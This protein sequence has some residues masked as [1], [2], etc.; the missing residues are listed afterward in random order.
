MKFSKQL[1]DMATQIGTMELHG[2]TSMQSVECEHE[3]YDL[4][5][6]LMFSKLNNVEVPYKHRFN[7]EMIYSNVQETLLLRRKLEL[8]TKY[9]DNV[10]RKELD[11]AGI[12]CRDER[13]LS[14]LRNIFEGDVSEENQSN[15]GV[16]DPVD[17][18]KNIRWILGMPGSGKV[19][20]L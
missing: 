2:V 14:F 12:T 5:E 3:E 9:S 10:I 18:S 11:S 8:V 7:K 19:R 13:Y 16:S 20:Y 6:A 1:E 17:V 15:N 4:S